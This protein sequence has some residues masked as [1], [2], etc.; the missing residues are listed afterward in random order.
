MGIAEDRQAVRLHGRG[1]LDAPAHLLKPLMGQ[2]VHQVEVDPRHP[3]G[4]QALHRARHQLRRLLTVDGFLYLGGEILHAE[5]GSVDAAIAQR[6]DK[7]IAKLARIDLNR[8][9]GILR[10]VEDIAH[11]AHDGREILGR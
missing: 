9:L 6:R 4:A 7:V 1:D 11:Q 8:E 2:A 3:G 10:D 5:A